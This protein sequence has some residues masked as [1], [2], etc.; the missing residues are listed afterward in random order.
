[1]KILNLSMKDKKSQVF[2]SIFL[3]GLFLVTLILLIDQPLAL[4]LTFAAVIGVVPFFIKKPIYFLYFLFLF[5]PS[6]RAL[7]RNEQILEYFNFNALLHIMLLSIGAWS[8]WQARSKIIKVVRNYRFICYLIAFVVLAFVSVFYSIEKSSTINHLI[9]LASSSL[10]IL[11]FAISVIKQKKDFY[12]LMYAIVLGALI[13]GLVGYYELFT[14]AG[15]YDSAMREF[16]ING[17]FDHPVIFSEYMFFT[18]L[19][20]YALIRDKSQ[21]RF[22]YLFGSI[23][24]SNLILAVSSLTRG[25][26]NGIIAAFMVFAGIKNVKWLIS[27]LIV[28]FLFF[29]FV[30]PINNRVMDVIRPSADSSFTTRLTIIKSTLPAF[31]SS[32][33][34]GYG[35]GA[36]DMVHLDYNEQAVFWESPQAHNDYLRLLI[37]LGIVGLFVYLAVFISL[38][39][40]ISRLYKKYKE[41]NFETYLLSIA[42]LWVA[43]GV[44]SIGDNFLRTVESQ[45]IAWAYTG[46]VI[47][48]LEIKKI[49]DRFEANR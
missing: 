26:W 22:K 18:A 21:D 31:V 27:G 10:V 8:I 35:F 30:E 39:L 9:R 15:W 20:L 42:L 40:L 32:P 33:L 29:V 44:I 5:T 45:Q 36:F 13:P 14:S 3:I 46:A 1:M 43:A 4:K 16:R 2:E 38:F 47:G 24:V 25:V 41:T 49:S 48:V 17:T 23:F 37:E 6:I 12:N 28:F 7:T 11:L 34:F 19:V